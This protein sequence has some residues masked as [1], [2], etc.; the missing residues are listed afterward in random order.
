MKR[1]GPLER[2]T[3]LRS[4]T[5]LRKVGARKLRESAAERRFRRAVRDRAKGWCEILSPSCPVGLH[6]GGHAHHVF[7]SDRDKGVHDPARGLFLCFPAHDW[8]HLHPVESRRLGW[9]MKEGD[10]WP[11]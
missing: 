7:P 11:L 9:L 3:P 8:V 6:A 5:P 1:S 10:R 4:R 2:R